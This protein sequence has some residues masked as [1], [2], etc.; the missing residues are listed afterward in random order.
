[1]LRIK[2]DLAD[3]DVTARWVRIF[4]AAATAA[5]PL[6]AKTR[7]RQGVKNAIETELA[8]FWSAVPS[9]AWR[10]RRSA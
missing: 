4:A 1:L 8:G 3:P 7:R 2:A 6:P 10:L 9:R 5:L